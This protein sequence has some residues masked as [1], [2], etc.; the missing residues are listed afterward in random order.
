MK[1]IVQLRQTISEKTED[2]A[3]IM[4]LKDSSFEYGIIIIYFI[5]C[6]FLQEKLKSIKL[7]KL[8]FGN[9]PVSKA[10]RR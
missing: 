2:V 10:S 5:Y 6:M 3:S 4:T 8:S 9:T 7:T 1:Y